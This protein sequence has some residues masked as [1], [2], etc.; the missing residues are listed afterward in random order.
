DPRQRWAEDTGG[1]L[2][3]V[4]NESIFKV[5]DKRTIVHNEAL[6]EVGRISAFLFSLFESLT[7]EEFETL[8]NIVVAGE[9]SIEKVDL[10]YYEVGDDSGQPPAPGTLGEKARYRITN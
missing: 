4:T 3:P 5:R 6:I 8:F 1:K 10:E 2:F 9:D 7:L